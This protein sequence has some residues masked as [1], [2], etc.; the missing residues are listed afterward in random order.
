MARRMENIKVWRLPQAQLGAAV[1]EAGNE[2]KKRVE[3]FS[4]ATC[5]QKYV[6]VTM[7]TNTINAA[8][9]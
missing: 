2:K 4:A 6:N 8:M 5:W 7:I 3:E 1:G 9:K